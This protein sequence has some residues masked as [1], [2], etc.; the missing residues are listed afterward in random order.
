MIF[1]RNANSRTVSH[2]DVMGVKVFTRP[3]L[4]ACFRNTQK[5]YPFAFF[6][7]LLSN[8][9]LVRPLNSK[10]D[11]CNQLKFNDVFGWLGCSVNTGELRFYLELEFGEMLSTVSSVSTYKTLGAKPMAFKTFAM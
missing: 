10:A 2:G 4:F 9:S 6:Y 7:F 3:R 5:D 11:G 1:Q 8:F